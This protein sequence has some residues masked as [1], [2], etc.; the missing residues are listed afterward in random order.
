[1]LAA[2]PAL[3]DAPYLEKLSRPWD[4]RRPLPIAAGLGDL[5]MLQLLLD[6]GAD[7][8]SANGLDETALHCAAARRQ[9]AAVRFLLAAGAEIRCTSIYSG[10]PLNAAASAGDPA[11]VRELILAGGEVATR[12]AFGETPLHEA[13]SRRH[14]RLDGGV[15][16]DEA[17][18]VRLLLAAGAAVDA[19]TRRG[20]TAL[21]QAAASG[22]PAGAGLLLAQGAS[23]DALDAWGRTPLS[24][25]VECH[26]TPAAAED[27]GHTAVVQ[28]LVAAGADTH[29]HVYRPDLRQDT[30]HVATDEGVLLAVS[31]ARGH[32]AVARWLRGHGAGRARSR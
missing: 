4:A 21:H 6:R 3:A 17:E 19:R 16:A 29:V 14:G 12:N 28:L 24:R 13:V 20:E 30:L 32:A 23:V 8:E 22:L 9:L 10:G 18:V 1:M 27:C 7:L 26:D 2:H 25:A 11:I 5:A 31:E 15:A